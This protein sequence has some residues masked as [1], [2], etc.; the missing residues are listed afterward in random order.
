MKYFSNLF[1]N[2]D[3]EGRFQYSFKKQIFVQASYVAL[4]WPMV[5]LVVFAVLAG[6]ATAI[7]KQSEVLNSLQ[8]YLSD[9][10]TYYAILIPS[11][12]AG[13]AGGKW[14]DKTK[15]GPAPTKK[16]RLKSDD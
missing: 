1:G 2:E 13:Y 5:G 14:I 9:T 12:C 11:L 15:Q 10:L 4:L 6:S 3:E 8:T 7:L 16:K